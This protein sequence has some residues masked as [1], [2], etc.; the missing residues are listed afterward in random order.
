M[1]L[2]E[3]AQATLGRYRDTKG[4]D[5]KVSVATI[6][7]YE[8]AVSD[9]LINALLTSLKREYTDRGV[10]S[11]LS[12]C[13]TSSDPVSISRYYMNLNT[14]PD[15]RNRMRHLLGHACLIIKALPIVES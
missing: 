6:E 11:L 8:I 15:V 9:F 14:G 3:S 7:I 12:G 13:C 1:E 10:G 4:S 5:R 2:E